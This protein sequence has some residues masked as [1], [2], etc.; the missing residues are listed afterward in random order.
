ME[1]PNN[2]SQ[3]WIIYVGRSQPWVNKQ[4]IYVPEI[5]LSRMAEMNLLSTNVQYLHYCLRVELYVY[6]NPC[7]ARDY[8]GKI[9]KKIIFLHHT[10]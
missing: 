1:A 7:W 3:P 8:G 5:L 2:R 4:V 9:Y 6:R 10:D